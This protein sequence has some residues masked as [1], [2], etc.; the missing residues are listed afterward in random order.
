VQVNVG[1]GQDMCDVAKHGVAQMTR[2]GVLAAK[3]MTDEV[4]VIMTNGFACGD[5]V[6]AG[7][8]CDSSTTQQGPGTV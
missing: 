2:E 3:A 4:W 6:H 5:Y 8:W 7:K 1:K